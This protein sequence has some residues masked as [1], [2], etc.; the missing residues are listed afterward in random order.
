LKEAG[1]VDEERERAR[2]LV[3]QLLA[4]G[5][6]EAGPPTEDFLERVRLRQMGAVILFARN[7]PSLESALDI[8]RALDEAGGRDLLVAI[9]EEGGWVS[10]LPPPWPRLPAAMALGA[11][12]AERPEA[13][14]EYARSLGMALRALGIVQDYAPVLDVNTAPDNPIIGSRAFG[15]RPEQV[16]RLGSAFAA[17]LEE[18]GVIATGKHF[19]GHGDTRVDSHLDLP[20]LDFDLE[21]LEAVELVP[22]RRAA[23]AGMSA[24]M[25]AHVALPAVA[26]APGLP[27]TL[28][29]R[30]LTDLVRVR[31]GYD[32]LVVTDCMEMQGITR[33]HGTARAC[34][35]AIAAGADQVLVSHTATLQAAA[36]EALE[37]AVVDGELAPAR[38]LKAAGRVARLRAR[39]AQLPPPLP[40]AEA[41]EALSR[42]ADLLAE[43]SVYLMP[44]A[45][46]AASERVDAWL[47]PDGGSARWQAILGVAGEAAARAAGE[48]ARVIGVEESGTPSALPA[49]GSRVVVFV[50]SLRRHPGWLD[51][52]RRLEGTRRMAIVIQDPYDAARLPE[53]E[54]LVVAPTPSPA[55]VAR[56]VAVLLGKARAEG[57]APIHLGGVT[58]QLPEASFSALEQ[59]TDR[60]Q[61]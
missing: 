28:S 10:R 8:R 17:G 7:V 49:P 4:C 14:R 19:P 18:A 44:G 34:V 33:V 54:R 12:A 47:V 23:A 11:A 37:R 6:Q 42:A 52:W 31:M 53:A 2:E 5:Y 24:F 46:D 15:D 22:F 35:L 50:P 59:P 57:R 16:A 9:D 21:R 27:A 43:E 61:A 25:T 26:E 3:G 39:V 30:V 45:Q 55:A 48:G 41:L 32:G 20:V 36:L 60:P 38:V 1:A 29:R 58:D 51:L 56:A 40:V 13:V